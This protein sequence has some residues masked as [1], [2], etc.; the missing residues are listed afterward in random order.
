MDH[1]EDGGAPSSVPLGNHGLNV[2]GTPEVCDS[3]S[4]GHTLCQSHWPGQEAHSLRRLCPGVTGSV[5]VSQA[6]SWWSQL[7]WLWLVLLGAHPCGWQNQG[8]PGKGEDTS[9]GQGSQGPSH[10]PWSSPSQV[11]SIFR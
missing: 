8:F 11:S 6:L 4:V 3:L 9:L 1:R 5:L 2:C 10:S 7:W